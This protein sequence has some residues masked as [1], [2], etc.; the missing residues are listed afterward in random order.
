MN[1][2][3][4]LNPRDI[5]GQL[6]KKYHRS[7][8]RYTSYPTAPQF[9]APFPVE[10]LIEKWKETNK[11]DKPVSIYTHFPF[12]RSRCLYCGC[13]TEINHTPEKRRTYLQALKREVESVFNIIDGSRN[14]SQLAM[15][16]G[17]PTSMTTEELADYVA[18]LEKYAPVEPYAERSIEIDP[19]SIDVHY[20]DQLLRMGF[21]R[22]SFG[23]QDLDPNVQKIINRQLDEEQ[24]KKLIRHLRKL[25]IEAINL[26]LIYGLPG[27][28]LQSFSTT[29]ETVIQLSPSRI[30]LFGYAHV[31]WVSP[32]QEAMEKHGVPGPQE[33][34]ALFGKAFELL[35]NAGYRHVGMDH[36]ARPTDELISALNNRTL[37][38]NF[39]GYTT[40]RGLDLIGIGASSISSVGKSY[41]QNEKD[42]QRYMENPLPPHW[43][44]GLIMS[45]EDALRREIIMELFCNFYLD[46]KAVE[47]KFRITFADHFQEQ[48]NELRTM[49]EDGLL[50]INDENLTIT[51]L[52]R[53]FVRNICMVFDGY[54]AREKEDP[55][56]RYSKTI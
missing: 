29:I 33:R 45:D 6:L 54:L 56:K 34:M 9:K 4:Y 3:K 48:L 20:L 21:N 36:F 30:A 11:L 35:V 10:P 42:I 25:G 1:E 44:K 5:P 12:C 41:T 38:R 2:T 28:D 17:T 51:E 13:F 8:P 46:K 16:G 37:T 22:F 55:G 40:R 14:I 23:V 50:E 43:I 18:H 24:L 7:G 31:P 52:G 47:N 39:M 49:E 27:Q 26:D 32:H 19:R 15:G 53:F